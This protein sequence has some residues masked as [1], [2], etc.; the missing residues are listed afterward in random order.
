[1][2]SLRERRTGFGGTPPSAAIVYSTVLAAHTLAA[3]DIVPAKSP[4]SCYPVVIITLINNRKNGVG[5]GS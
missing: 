4:V 5:D 2:S 1:M 3:E